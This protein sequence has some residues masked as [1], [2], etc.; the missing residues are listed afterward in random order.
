MKVDL[1]TSMKLGG[2]NLLNCLC[3]G[4]N[5]TPYWEMVIS[6]D[7]KA[8]FNMFWPQ[9]NIGRW[10]DA[11]MRLEKTI[12]FKIPAKVE[13]AML[14]NV[15][16]FFDN[17]DNLCLQ[18]MDFD[19]N[20]F[21]IELHS[22]REGLLALNALI[23]YR[24]SR[25]AEEK[26]HKMLETVERIVNEDC[27]WDLEK[28]D[29]F[30]NVKTEW[31]NQ[32]P[33]STNGRLIE[34]LVWYYE[35]TGDVLAFRL[36]RK[37]A[38]WHYANSTNPDGSINEVCKAHHTHS[39]FGTLRGLYLFGK[40]TRQR[41]YIERVV[42][43]YKTTVRTLVKESGYTSHDLCTEFRG[44]TTS[45]GDAAQLALWLAMDG[46]PEF[47]DDAERL[48]RARILPSQI[49][50]TP[51]LI[52]VEND[53]SDRHFNLTKRAIGGFGGMHKHPHGGKMNTTDI[54][55]ADIHTLTDI[56]SHI[57]VKDRDLVYVLFHFDYSD[58][59]ITIKSSRS[60]VGTLD[61][62]YSIGKP[63][64]I[65]LPSWVDRGALLLEVDGI[66]HM[67]VYM[68][69]YL[70][71][72]TK[73]K[74]SNIKLSYSLPYKKTFE[75]TEGTEYEILWK[76]DEVISISPNPNYYPFYPNKD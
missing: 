65:R 73:T 50:E 69:N 71:V 60:E 59:E 72:E 27:S 67:P 32:N 21:P 26:A 56:Y 63:M 54:T 57:V 44:E 37:F 61:I 42:Q 10:W 12:G 2:D 17:P 74:S 11:M 29:Y 36:A 1:I 22:L 9:H 35:S 3:P 19:I 43:C 18:P 62:S 16:W 14:E 51:E 24:G 33:V 31:E 38:E 23:H 53:D 15:Y 20:L 7:Y 55:G 46:Y 66:L 76:G 40:L 58:D 8:E 41:K 34:A 13:G 6:P 64:L 52:P 70:C 30:K 28:L 68:N 75:K 47:L 5:Y 45:P 4:K 48:V 25:W 39:F 49:I